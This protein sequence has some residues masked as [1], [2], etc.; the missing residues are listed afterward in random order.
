MN[1]TIA[2]TVLV[3]QTLAASDTPMSMADVRR[4]LDLPKSTASDILNTLLDL[5][6]LAFDTKDHVSLGPGIAFFELAAA[7]TNKASLITV[8]RTRM[9]MLADALDDSVH[10]WVISGTQMM[11]L[12]RVDS[13]QDRQQEF[14]PGDLLP[15][16]ASAAGKAVLATKSPAE[17]R[18][19]LGPGPFEDYTGATLTRCEDLLEDLALSRKR[20]Y[21]VDERERSKSLVSVAA[22]ICREDRQAVAAISM[23]CRKGGYSA[24]RVGEV[25]PAVYAA[26]RD[27]SRMMGFTG[28]DLYTPLC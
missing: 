23:G 5:K 6:I 28:E 14:F 10:L 17:V 13:E 25:G 15:M 7:F 18:D 16:H 21:A 9:K 8:A 11:A 24:K 22:P 20:K 19:I 2:R 27:I 4:E 1:K 3:L 26:A 12:E